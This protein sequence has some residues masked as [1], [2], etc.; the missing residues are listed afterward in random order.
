MA[1]Q[2]ALRTRIFWSRLNGGINDGT[3]T[4]GPYNLIDVSVPSWL[5]R[6]IT[7]PIFLI[8]VTSAGSSPEP[9]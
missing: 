4:W 9:P 5:K 1:T 8:A 7:P 6:T 3:S 2:G